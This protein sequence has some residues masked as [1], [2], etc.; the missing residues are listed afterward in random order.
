MFDVYLRNI[1]YRLSN[2]TLP[3]ANFE[4]TDLGD[5]NMTM[6]FSVTFN[7]PYLLGLLVKRSDRFF[8]Q[9]KYNL[10]DTRGYFKPEYQYFNGMLL[11]N[12]TETTIFGTLCRQDAVE[13]LKYPYLDA[14]GG[15]ETMY[16]RQ[17]LELL[18]DYRGKFLFIN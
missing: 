12:A 9:L 7:Q 1:T 16:G 15:R 3:V 13:N 2:Q 8:I 14:T 10:V 6:N 5:D 18:F 17:R 4:I 11:G